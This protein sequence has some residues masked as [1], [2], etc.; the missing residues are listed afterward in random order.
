MFKICHAEGRLESKDECCRSKV[1]S[2][3]IYMYIYFI[4][5]KAYIIKIMSTISAKRMS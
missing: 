5:D 3:Y 1:F 4:R 2:H